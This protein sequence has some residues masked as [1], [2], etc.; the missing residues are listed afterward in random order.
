MQKLAQITI[1]STQFGG[2]RQMG[3]CKNWT[4]LIDMSCVSTVRDTGERERQRQTDR[5]TDRQTKFRHVSKSSGDTRGSCMSAVFF[6]LLASS[7]VLKKN[8]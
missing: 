6:V 2:T 7:V 5:E 8:I 3:E 4:K 1:R